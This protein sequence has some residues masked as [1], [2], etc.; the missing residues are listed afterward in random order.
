MPATWKRFRSRW[1]WRP[2]TWRSSPCDR[3]CRRSAA[4]WRG[5]TKLVDGLRA[6]L[7]AEVAEVWQTSTWDDPAAQ[8]R[9]EGTDLIVCLG[10]DGSM[11]WAAR[12]VV[13]HP[14]PIL[15]GNMGRPGFL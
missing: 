5:A 12:A 6:A 10:G 1:T 11:L 3:C 13:P 2:W 4:C 9:I 8:E 15:G 7:A 14:G